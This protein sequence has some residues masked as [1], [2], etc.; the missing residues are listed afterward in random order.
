M[1]LIKASHEVINITIGFKTTITKRSGFLITFDY[2]T[3]SDDNGG[4]NKDS[5]NGE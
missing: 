4:N 1:R 5:E 3:S 2:G